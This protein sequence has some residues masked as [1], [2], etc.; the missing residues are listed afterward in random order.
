MMTWFKIKRC[1]RTGLFFMTASFDVKTGRASILSRRFATVSSVR[2]SSSRSSVYVEQNDDLV[3]NKKMLPNGLVFY[4]M[5]LSEMNDEDKI[6]EAIETLLREEDTL[7][8]DT[9]AKRLD[10]IDARPYFEPGHHS[11]LRGEAP[12]PD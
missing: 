9:V 10:K 6:K 8:L 3:Q 7:T 1:F 4:Y 11:A 2:V 5:Y 12:V